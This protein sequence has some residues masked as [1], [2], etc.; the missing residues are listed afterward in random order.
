[1]HATY[2]VHF[3]LPTKI[4]VINYDDKTY[5]ALHQAVLPFLLVAS[6]DFN[7]FSSKTLSLYFKIVHFIPRAELHFAFKDR[8]TLALVF[9]LYVHPSVFKW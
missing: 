4:I 3:T 1:M 9:K 6:S 8:I 2:S 5:K 7:I